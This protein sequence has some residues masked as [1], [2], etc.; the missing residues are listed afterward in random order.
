MKK[1]FS[2]ILLTLLPILANADAVE[3]DGIYYNLI[4]KGK[5]AEVT[6]NPNKYTGAVNIPATFN[7]E[8]TEFSVTSIGN[9]AFYEC[10]ALTS[11]TIPESVSSIGEWTF[12][13]CE[14][15][16]SITIPN[17]VTSISDYTFSGCRGLTYVTIP[18]SVTSIGSA[19]FRNCRSLTF[20]NIPN[21]VTNIGQFAFSGCSGLTSITI[22][23]SVTSISAYTFSNCES[24]TSV[25]IPNNVTSIGEGAFQSCSGLTSITIPDGVTSIGHSSFSHCSGLTSITIPNSVTN[26]E[27]SSFSDCSNLTSVIIGNNVTSIGSYVFRGCSSLTSVTIPNSV[28]SIGIYAFSGCTSLNSVFIG[29]SVTSI[30][31]NTFSNC[32]GLTSVTIPNSVTSIGYGAYS[33]CSGLTSITIGNGVKSIGGYAFANCP[34]LIDVYCYVEEVPNTDGNAFEG[35]YIEY[36]T[37]HAPE[38]AIE[39]YRTTEPWSSFGSIVP[40]APESP[41]IIFADALV[42]EICVAN[43]D[44]NGDGELSEEE[45]AA[46][47]DLGTVFKGNTSITSFNELQY[48]TGLTSIGGWAFYYCSGLTSITIPNNVTD[49]G[50]NVFGYCSS[51]ISIK[52]EE[53]NTTYDSRDGCNAIIETVTNT[54]ITGCQNTV[55]PNSV[56]SIGIYAFWGCSSLTSINIPNSVTSIGEG[57]FSGCSKLT[58][59][60]IPESVT[61]IGSQAFDNCKL[62]NVL[63]K[64]TTPPEGSLGFS[65]QTYAHT[66]LYVPVG[67]WDAYAY[68]DA[69]YKFNNIRETA[70]TEEEVS[71]QQAYTLMDAES[72]AYSVYDPVNECVGTINSAGGINEDNPNHCWQVIEAEGMHYLY[73]IGARKYVRREGSHFALIDTPEPIEVENGNNGIILGAQEAHQWALVSNERMSVAQSAI[74]EVTGISPIQTST[75]EEEQV[76]DLHGRKLNKPQKGINII[77]Y[78]DGTTKKVLIK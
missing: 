2:L 70:T 39:Q 68:D 42:K 5:I 9:S 32:S 56:T 62:R 78:S 20:V 72:F 60:T 25:I 44:T 77:R 6:S 7:Y 4:P 16:T 45:A 75:N 54:L 57:A 29:N 51:L 52:V 63:I 66:T 11:V 19:A 27:Q 37:L 65:K 47:T 35:S 49:I 61:S 76:C 8:G 17:R 59:I 36:A 24:L 30:S 14:G 64:C 15:L 21:S 31:N 46:V 71:E 41:N 26:I 10:T 55:I 40:I 69:W 34:E 73:N 58:S 18:N 67:C 50:W 53:G 74:D 3:I 12:S 48:F 1:I 28:K 22:P 33:G 43:W 23:N 38:S 13:D